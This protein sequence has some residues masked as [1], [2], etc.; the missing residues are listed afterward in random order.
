MSSGKGDRPGAA[1]R[2][3]NRLQLGVSMPQ[4][5]MEFGTPQPGPA[6]VS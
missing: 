6:L 3:G 5:R 4:M 1:V 2:D